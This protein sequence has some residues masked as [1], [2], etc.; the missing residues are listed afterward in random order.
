VSPKLK[1]IALIAVILIAAFLFYE[2]DQYNI[3]NL[4][5]IKAILGQLAHFN[6]TTPTLFTFL[7]FITY[8]TLVAFSIP[9]A[10]ILTLAAGALFG[11]AKALLVVSLA[12][13]LGATLAFLSS[14]WLFRDYIQKKFSTQFKRLNQG[15]QH[16]GQFYIISLRVIPLFP[17]FLVNLLLGLTN[18]PIMVFAIF[19]FVG[20]IPASFIY[21]QAGVHLSRITSMQDI[22]SPSMIVNFTV[23]GLFTLLLAPIMKIIQFKLKLRNYPKPKNIDYNLVVIGGGAAGLMAA[24]IGKEAKSKVALIEKHLMGGDCLNT[25]CIPSKSLIKSA[26]VLNLLKN[27]S[28]FGIET[29]EKHSLDYSKIKDRIKNIQN[30]IAPVD[31]RERYQALG[32]DCFEGRAEIISPYEVKVYRGQNSSEELILTTK[33]IVVA[34]G[35]RPIIPSIPGLD[36]IPFV[37]SDNIW[38]IKNV[39]AKLLVL[40]GG[41]IGIE[42]A[43]SYR[44]LG[45]E[46]TIITRGPQLLPKEDKDV[47]VLIQSKL[48]KEGI[49]VIL[50]HE[51]K[52]FSKEG[53][54]SFAFLGNEVIPFDL[55]LLALGR[56]PHF[57]E[58]FSPKLQERL[59]LLPGK[60]PFVLENLA[61]AK[62]PNIF[63]CGDAQ[64]HWQ[65]THAAGA[66][67]TYAA[68]NALLSPYWSITVDE[69]PM[70]RCTFSDP[71]V[72]QVGHTEG[73]LLEKSVPYEIYKLPINELDRINTDF[74]PANEVQGFIKVLTPPESDEILGATIVSPHAGEMLAELTLAMKYKIGLKKILATI[75]PYPTMSEGI[76]RVAGLWQKNHMPQFVFKIMERWNSW[77]R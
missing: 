58:V 1:K 44:R 26:S 61:M 70:P 48:E 38:E 42:M 6:Q 20:M 11:G 62:V 4:E 32:V 19:S 29:L 3:S 55:T 16:Q 35:G 23:L 68:L 2:A 40:G 72:A 8:V 22:M 31:S 74:G 49:K 51:V 30:K 71:E 43:Q 66:Q 45:S 34:T 15:L 17:F 39:P 24:Y 50:N 14:R 21:T 41:P 56:E 73:Q 36:K 13:T 12:S 25:G 64:G 57:Q 65:L 5:G 67:G 69:W 27:A 59:H 75:H 53:D 9:A 63:V 52:H 10:T 60:A 7:F 46:V 47:G 76:R 33:S 37:T 18:I 28:N 54:L 77:R